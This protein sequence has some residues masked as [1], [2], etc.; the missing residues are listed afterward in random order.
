MTGARVLDAGCGFGMTCFGF[1]AADDAPSGIVGLDPSAGKI[2]VMRKLAAFLSVGEERVRPIM[3]DAL[4]MGFDD[5][6]FDVVFVKDVTSHIR[7]RERFHSGIARVL[8]KGGRLLLTDENNALDIFG[9]LPRKRLWLQNEMGPLPAGLWMPQPYREMRR[10]MIDEW[11]TD[12]P[13]ETREHLAAESKGMWGED[14]RTAI[15]GFSLGSQFK[16]TADFPYRHPQS[17]EYM[18]YPLNPFKLAGDLSRFGLRAKVLRPWFA[19]GKKLRRIAGEVIRALHPLSI[20]IQ[21][22]FYILAVK[23]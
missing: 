15:E 20:F 19:S 4:D 10:G 22:N 7:D 12:L 13:E 17:G 11:R 21:P 3:G 1:M 9:W 8:R 23:E 6:S 18:E 14:L 16:N 5:G 2:E